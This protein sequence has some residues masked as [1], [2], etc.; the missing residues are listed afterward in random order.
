MIVRMVKACMAPERKSCRERCYMQYSRRY[1]GA[2]TL[3]GVASEVV[4]CPV[5]PGGTLPCFPAAAPNAEVQRRLPA[6]RGARASQVRDKC[7]SAVPAAGE[8][9]RS[10]SVRVCIDRYTYPI[11]RYIWG[12]CRDISTQSGEVPC[13]FVVHGRACAEQEIREDECD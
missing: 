10:W 1:C 5:Q 11:R 7:S 3:G 4:A 12:C 8:R 9:D 2:A 13:A 6:R